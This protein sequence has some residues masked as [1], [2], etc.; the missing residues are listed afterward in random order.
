MH[1]KHFYQSPDQDFTS[2][3]NYVGCNDLLQIHVWMSHVLSI[4][5]KIS[6]N[7][8]QSVK[9]SFLPF[10]RKITTFETSFEICFYLYMSFHTFETSLEIC[11]Y[12]CMSFH[13][14]HTDQNRVLIA[15]LTVIRLG[16][17]CPLLGMIDLVC[18]RDHNLLRFWSGEHIWVDVPSF[19]RGHKTA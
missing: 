4:N 2:S 9:R 18:A 19:H 1:H 12:L 17:F 3:E 15:K 6:T 11:F 5:L 16:G 8:C 10:S 14:W 7:S 13:H